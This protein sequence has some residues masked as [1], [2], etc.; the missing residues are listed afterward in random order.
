MASAAHLCQISLEVIF[1][2]GGGSDGDTAHSWLGWVGVVCLSPDA[3]V[4]KLARFT[5]KGGRN[6]CV[7]LFF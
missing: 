3:A 6:H 1:N 5:D 2:F 7:P 4:M